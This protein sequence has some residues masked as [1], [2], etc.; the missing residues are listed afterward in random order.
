MIGAPIDALPYIRGVQLILTGYNGYTKGSRI[1]NDKMVRQEIIRATGRVRSHMQNIF[2]TQFKSGNIDAARA[3]KQCMENCDYLIE[4]V[5]KAVAGMEH[6]F[7]SGQRSTTHG[8]LKKLIKHDHDVI[9]MV[10]KAVNIA[11]SAEHSIATG[12]G[13]Y[14]QYIMQTTQMISSCKGFFGARANLLAGLKQKKKK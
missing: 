12:E 3:A 11:N 2:D 1:E 10:T 8:D 6:A 13:D 4:D 5:N 9:E 7:L 14:Q